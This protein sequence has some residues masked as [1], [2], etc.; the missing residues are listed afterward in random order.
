VIG[1]VSLGP[2]ACIWF[3]AVLRG[4]DDAIQLGERSHILDNCILHA[5]YGLPVLIGADCVVGPRAIL[6]GCIIGSN[7][8]I[9]AGATVLNGAKLGHSCIVS[10]GTLITEQKVFPDN[11]LIRGDRHGWFRQLTEIPL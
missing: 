1:R 9:G 5:D 4:D 3:G 7:S 11:S 6:H 2:D 8:L 10:P